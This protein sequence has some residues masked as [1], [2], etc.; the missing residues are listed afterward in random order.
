MY[1]PMYLQKKNK[2]KDNLKLFGITME[3]ENKHR[4]LVVIEYGG[5]YEDSWEDVI[6]AFEDYESAKEYTDKMKKMYSAIDEKTYS[7][8]TDMLGSEEEKIAD[9]Y[10]VLNSIE[11]LPGM[12]E[13]DYYK[14]LEDFQKNGKYDLIKKNFGID[15]ETFDFVEMKRTYCFSGYMIKE[16]DLFHKKENNSK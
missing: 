4:I 11:L 10:Y 15:R 1:K 9:K 8:I 5:E 7:E 13:S 3:Q 14:E 6:C 12:K 16:I 2:K